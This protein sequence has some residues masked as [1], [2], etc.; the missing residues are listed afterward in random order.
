MTANEDFAAAKHSFS[1]GLSIINQDI[2]SPQVSLKIAGIID[3]IITHSKTSSN[4]DFIIPLAMYAAEIHNTFERDAMMSRIISS[5]QTDVIHPSSTDPY[6]IMAYL[7][8]RSDMAKEDPDVIELVSRVLR[9][10]AD[11]FVRL[12]GLVGLA[13]SLI[14][15]Q[16]IPRA[17]NVL[18]EIGA[19]LKDLPAEYQKILLLSD[20]AILYRRIDTETA[21]EC[22]M[23]GIPRLD[24]VEYDREA[25]ARRQIVFAIVRLN[26]ILPER[27]WV[28]QCPAGGPEDR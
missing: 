4:P 10:I 6:E 26:T 19:G 28:D 27:R 2:K 23:D 9:M 16:D 24:A 12:S 17:K 14:R 5:L 1:R 20:L 21:S 8:Q 18:E 15:L 22:L 11:P 25:V 13:E 3:I 7:L